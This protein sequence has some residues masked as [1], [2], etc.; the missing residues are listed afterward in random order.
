MFLED[1]PAS[2]LRNSLILESEDLRLTADAA[3][4]G[5]LR[6]L[7][8]KR[9][10]REFF[11]QDRRPAF[12][13]ARGYCYHDIGGYDECFPTIVSCRGITPDGDTYDYADHGHLWQLAWDAKID[14]GVLVMRCHIPELACS[15][16][17]RCSFVTEASLLLQYEIVNRSR[18]RVPYVYSAH[19]M[20]AGDEFMRV[21]LP[22]GMRRAFNSMAAD[23]F[24]LSA[25][26]W[27]DLPWRN[28]ADIEGP[29]RPTRR[30]F[31][32]LFS[33]RLKEGR[34]AVEYLDCRQR[35]EITYD[36]KRLPYLGFYACQG[37]DFLDDG[38][39]AD[40]CLLAFEPATGLGDDIPGCLRSGTSRTLAPNSS[41]A[42]WICL[43]VEGLA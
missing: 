30:T 35:L 32:K 9:T 21:V 18:Q 7:V 43:T 11:Y 1:D 8:S 16:I 42:F 29:F 23:S 4:G 38:E 24:G 17:R 39:F 14:G 34:A 22:K 20:L 15:F 36:V 12:D 5:K 27:F 2:S 19:P 40:K 26:Q 37:F 28:H 31:I 13:P 33:D 3:C 41:I 25:G 6:S 10:G